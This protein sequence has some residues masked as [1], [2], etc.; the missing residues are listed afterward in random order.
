MRLLA[1]RQALDL[2]PLR[3]SITLTLASSELRTKTGDA[4]AAKHQRS[5]QRGRRQ[6]DGA[7]QEKFHRRALQ[8]QRGQCVGHRRPS[9]NI[10]SMEKLQVNG[11]G[12]EVQRLPGS[13]EP[14]AARQLFSCMKGW[15]QWPCG[16][17]GRRRSARE[18][19]G[20][21]SCTR[22]AATADPIPFPMFAA[23]GASGPTT[24]TA[25]RCKC[26]RPCWPRSGIEQPGSAGPL[27][28]RHHRPALCEPLSG[29]RLHRHG[30]ACHRR[31]PVGAVDRRPHAP[32]MAPAGCA[33]AWAAIT[34][35]WTAPSGNGTTS[36]CARPFAPSIS[37]TECRRIE[38]PVLAIQG[39][40]DP[41]GTLRQIEEI[42][43]PGPS[44]E[45]GVAAM[46]PFAAPGPARPGA[47]PH[48]PVPGRHCPDS[49]GSSAA[50]SAADNHRHCPGAR[51]GGNC[52]RPIRDRCSA[53]T[54]LPTAAIIRLTWWYLPSVRVSRR[55]PSPMSSHA[56]ARTG[57]GS[58]SS[59]HTFQQPLR[60]AARPP[61][62]GPSPRTPWAR[63]AAANSS[64]G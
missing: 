12:I 46:R 35:T 23:P 19:A 7:A 52:S 6:P 22:G 21:A 30:A 29:D 4:A 62:A 37:G 26:C 55:R 50:R 16:A 36:G 59:T 24:C 58:S 33:S 32:P 41:Y 53:S 61:D 49:A 39:E 28:R 57:W 18:P 13:P 43:P 17:T 56:A 31:R 40:D 2:L 1:G 14:T 25:R 9:L 15:A 54:R 44:R 42:A 27:R 47:A 38:A 45:A 34:A 63:D 51:S 3:G 64:G 5:S 48:R 60:P 11:V 20:T 10:P 8:G